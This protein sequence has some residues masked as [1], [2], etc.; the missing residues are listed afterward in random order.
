MKPLMISLTALV[1][2][3]QACGNTEEKKADVPRTTETIPV[4]VMALQEE[5]LRTE[6]VTAGT[7]STDDETMLSFKTGGVIRKILV[8]EG[9]AVRQGQLLASLDL[10]E[11]DA[12]VAQARLALEKAQR[13]FARVENLYRDSV[14]TLEQFQNA[15]TGLDIAQQQMDAARFNRSYSEIRAQAN[16]YVLRKMANEGQVVSPGTAVLQTNGAGRGQWILK[17]GVSDREWAILSVGDVATITTDARPNQPLSGKVTRKSEGT[18]MA[19]GTFAI[20]VTVTNGKGLASGLFGKATIQTTVPQRVWRIPYAALLDGDAQS[21]YVFVTT[22]GQTAQ[23]IP[24]T[25]GSIEKDRVVITGGLQNDQQLIVSGSAYLREGSPI[26][27][28]P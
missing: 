12:Q 10:T 2:L 22:D 27:I 3:I 25:I 19:N 24:V 13:D 15:S 26:R 28:Q 20:E 8:K 11:I 7:F 1:L 16:G 5:P 9:D 14:A 6:V 4:Q 18:D 21:G 23:R 17:A